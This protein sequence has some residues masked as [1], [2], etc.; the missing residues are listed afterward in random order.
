MTAV[1]KV[2]L[3]GF[4]WASPLSAL[5]E[6]KQSGSDLNVAKKTVSEYRALRR[7][8]TVYRHDEK[9]TCFKELI[10]SEQDYRMAKDILMVSSTT[11]NPY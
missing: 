2:I 7:A 10:E 4:F 8:C 5:A 3:M 6:A 11:A 9:R 1:A